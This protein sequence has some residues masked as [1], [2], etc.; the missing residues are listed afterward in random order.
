MVSLLKLIERF[1]QKHILDSFLAQTVPATRF[2]ISLMLSFC[3]FINDYVALGIF[4]GVILF[5]IMCSLETLK[6]NWP[7]VLMPISAG[8]ILGFGAWLRPEW[9]EYMGVSPTL[10]V[11][12]LFNLCLSAAVF[13][14]LLPQKDIVILVRKVRYPQVWAATIAGFRGMEIGAW[15]LKTVNRTLRTKRIRLLRHPVV[16]LDAFATGVLGHFLEFLDG[17]EIA[18]RTRGVESERF[19]PREGMKAVSSVD[20]LVGGLCVIGFVALVRW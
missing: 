18:L 10:L 4:T 1:L 13:R 6:E 16:L 9:M 19:T 2:L 5:L 3:I 14:I 11:W 7:V 15:A 20:V 17:F 8:I 12:K